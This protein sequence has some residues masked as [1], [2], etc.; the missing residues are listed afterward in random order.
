MVGDWRVSRAGS[1]LLYW[2]KLPYP[3]YSLHFSL[4]LLSVYRLVLWGWGLRNDRVYTLHCRFFL[5]IIH[6]PVVLKNSLAVVGSPT[7][8][9]RSLII[10][11]LVDFILFGVCLHINGVHL[12]F[13]IGRI[14][15]NWVANTLLEVACIF[16]GFVYIFM[17]ATYM[18]LRVSNTL[19][20]GWQNYF[21]REW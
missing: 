2:P 19:L 4:S 1:M 20:Q 5:I 10:L 17:W 14:H 21:L 3:Y 16:M 8:S 13:N 18:F 6:I 11:L 12:H 9:W 7:C 15:F